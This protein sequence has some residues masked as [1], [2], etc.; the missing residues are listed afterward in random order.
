MLSQCAATN[1]RLESRASWLSVLPRRVWRYREVRQK[2]RS[3]SQRL[4]RCDQQHW[5][6]GLRLRLSGAELR[7]ALKR[8]AAGANRGWRLR[9]IVTLQGLPIRA[10]AYAPQP[11]AQA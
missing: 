2:A 9:K 5:N 10:G 7:K 11:S 4:I 1:R 3:S 8:A 6:A